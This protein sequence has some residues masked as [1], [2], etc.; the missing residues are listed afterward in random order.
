MTAMRVIVL[1]KER[2]WQ[3]GILSSFPA[4]RKHHLGVVVDDGVLE[5][6]WL[7]ER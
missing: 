4:L 3:G 5:L 7:E 1:A 6:I 2:G